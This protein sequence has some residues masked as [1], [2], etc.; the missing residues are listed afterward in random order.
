MVAKRV[1]LT[2]LVLLILLVAGCNSEEASNP[3]LRRVTYEVTGSTEGVFI[4][5]MLAN[6]QVELIEDAQLPW[7]IS[8]DML[9]QTLIEV[10]V[11]EAGAPETLTCEIRIEGVTASKVSA[12]ENGIAWCITEVR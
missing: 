1:W 6:E 11:M 5:Y 7:K 8:I 12:N 10:M 3:N 2:Y 9:P 4:R